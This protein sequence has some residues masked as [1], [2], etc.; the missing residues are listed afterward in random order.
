LACHLQISADPVPDLGNHFDADPDADTAPDNFF[1]A[2]ADPGNQN[3][4]DPDPQQCVEVLRIRD[5][6]PDPGF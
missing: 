5:V 1:Y 4:A 2:D 3:D 6:K